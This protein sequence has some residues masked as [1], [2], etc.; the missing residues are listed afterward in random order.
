ML[1]GAFLLLG[2]N[3]LDR[4]LW[5]QEDIH[6]LRYA[7]DHFLNA[8]LGI[9]MIVMLLESARARSE[10]ISEKM[11]QFTM[12]TASSSQSVSLQ[13]LLQKVLTPDHRKR[14]CQSRNYPAAGRQRGFGGIRYVCVSWI[15]RNLLESAP[16]PFSE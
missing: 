13:E 16:P 8:S 10:E 9:G 5:T 4:K 6:L 3:N 7:F 1:A 14:E 12:L 11:R 15:Y 2:L